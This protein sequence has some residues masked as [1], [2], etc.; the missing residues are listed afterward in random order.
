M[1]RSYIQNITQS[2]ECYNCNFCLLMC[3]IISG[4]N[5]KYVQLQHPEG[6]FLS[7]IPWIT[8][9]FE[10]FSRFT[11]RFFFMILQFNITLYQHLWP[12]SSQHFGFLSLIV[13]QNSVNSVPFEH[14]KYLI[15]HPLI[16]YPVV[17]N[18]EVFKKYC[19]AQISGEKIKYSG[20]LKCRK[21]R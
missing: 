18:H 11:F 21:R 5:P 7:K 13:P 17:E 3:M 6:Y 8:C 1:C 14:P 4:L 10:N 12:S 15:K 19:L 20:G 16:L 2:S 9:L